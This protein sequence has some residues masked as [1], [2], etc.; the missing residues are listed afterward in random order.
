MAIMIPSIPNDF[1]PES[2]EG[3]LF[4]SLQRL[5]DDYYVFHSFRIINIIDNEWKE[6]E[7]DFVVFNRKKG[8]LCI[9]AKAGKVTCQ[10]GIFYYSSGMEMRDPFQQA[11][12]NKWKLFNQIY[13]FYHNNEIL[14]NCKVLS[15]VWFPSLTL[16]GLEKMTLPQHADK[17]LVLTEED[18]DNPLKTLERIFDITTA[19][20]EYGEMVEVSSDLP[21]DQADSLLQNILC[22]SFNILPSK[23]LEIDYKKEKFNALI[24]EQSNLLNYLEDQRS[25][26]I[27]GAAGT[28]KTMIA[29]EKARRHSI[30]GEKVLFLCFNVKLKEYLER[31]YE[32]PNVDYYTIDGFASKICNGF[33]ADY[34]ALEN[35]L[36]ELYE[37]DTFPY[38]HIIIDEGQDFGQERM[39][40]DNIFELLEEIVLTKGTGSFYV[41]YDKLQLVQSFEIPKFIER[42]DCRLTLYK[43][44]RNTKKI[45]ETS[46]K[47]LQKEPKL[48]DYAITGTMPNICFLSNH[49]EK[50]IL[51]NVIQQALLDGISDIQILSC[52]TLTDSRYQ[53]FLDEQGNYPYK[54]RS[55]KF[56]TCRKF[57]GLEADKIILVDVDFNALSNNNKVF[58][59]GASRARLELSIL[60]NMSEDEC[61]ML[62]NNMGSTVKKNNPSATLAKMLGCKLLSS[63]I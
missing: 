19:I 57:K 18:I 5:P 51:D 54:S 4:V 6:N 11:N 27:N 14:K 59:V 2:R 7:I 15:A 28:G 49:N 36:Y 41:F 55:I 29:V 13:N 31:T 32:Y 35:E 3:E 37:N 34:D 21:K 42:A 23:T 17:A 61:T 43:N 26:V 44:C 58:Y 46:F 16:D 33:N 39:R 24:K 45:A 12:S 22:P 1:S 47:P 25:A 40:S 10:N 48:F 53:P 20:K 62:I 30:K 56:T 52:A 50:E 60:A 63:H 38:Q 9:E 8:L